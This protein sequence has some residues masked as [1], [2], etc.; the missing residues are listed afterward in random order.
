MRRVREGEEGPAPP[1]RSPLVQLHVVRV[2]A[3]HTLATRPLEL[4]D[5]PVEQVEQ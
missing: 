4:H 2:E 3:Q 5:P 1:N